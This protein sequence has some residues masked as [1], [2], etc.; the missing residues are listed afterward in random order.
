[1]AIKKPV[2][3][4][5]HR[6]PS[7][8]ITQRVQRDLAQFPFLPNEALIGIRVVCALR[9]R[10]RAST[11]RDIAKGLLTEPVHVGSSTLF[12]VGGVRRSLPRG[13]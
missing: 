1:M 9:G 5:K 7:E 11:Y 6:G 8:N 12:Q 3:K 13:D 2:R 10:S 4:P